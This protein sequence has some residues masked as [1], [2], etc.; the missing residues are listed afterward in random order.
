MYTS[1]RVN[2]FERDCSKMGMKKILFSLG[3]QKNYVVGIAKNVT[4]APSVSRER[5]QSIRVGVESDAR[6]TKLKSF[7]VMS[8]ASPPL[9]TQLTQ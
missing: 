8:R 3:N 2:N 1:M 6:H 4:T 7:S 5:V 9:A